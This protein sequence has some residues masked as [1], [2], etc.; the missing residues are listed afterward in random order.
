MFFFTKNPNFKKNSIC[1]F[2]VFFFFLVKWM[3]GGREGVMA[4]VSE[5]LTMDP[6]KKCF[7]REKGWGE[8]AGGGGGG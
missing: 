4:R 2:S 8:V 5:C 7:W 6:N 3:G 1:F